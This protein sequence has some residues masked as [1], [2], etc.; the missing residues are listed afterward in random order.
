MKKLVLFFAI[1]PFYAVA[2]INETTTKPVALIALKKDNS[3]YVDIC[4]AVE[5]YCKDG[6]TIWKDKNS[7][8]IFYLMPPQLQLIKLRKDTGAYSMLSTWDFSKES[9]SESASDNESAK[10]NV[11]IY[12]ALYPLSKTKMAVALVSKWSTSY[13]GGGREEEYADFM[14]INDDGS[15]Q[16]A[17]KNI[18]FSSSEMI[19][20]CFTEDDYAKKSHC[21]DE[22]W[23]ILNLKITDNSKEYY[24]WKFITKSYT[25]PAFTEKTSVKLN[26]VESN[27]YPFQLQPLPDK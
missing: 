2:S 3:Q 20:A 6:T 19:R 7:N 5:S 1:V 15:Y 25:W 14:M 11:Y 22:N 17:F 8:K 23:S 9:K 24:D 26:T 13:S 27:A 4:K 10:E 16:L 18:L 12:P 21:H